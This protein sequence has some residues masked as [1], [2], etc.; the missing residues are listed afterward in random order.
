MGEP[1]KYG[2]FNE[3]ERCEAEGGII[4]SSVDELIA[5]ASKVD[6]ESVSIWCQIKDGL[7]NV[8]LSNYAIMKRIHVIPDPPMPT[9]EEE[10]AAE[11]EK[12]E[13]YRTR[14][15]NLLLK[16]DGSEDREDT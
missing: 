11:S 4:T 10:A 14:G 13:A 9:P 6:P 12:A 8:R 3:W 5:L 16:G 7:I 15:A 2:T 1:D